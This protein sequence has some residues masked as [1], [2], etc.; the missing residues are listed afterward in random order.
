MAISPIHQSRGIQV[1]SGLRPLAPAKTAPKGVDGFERVK[2]VTVPVLRRGSTGSAVQA[3]QVKL[4]AKGLMSR[5]DFLNGTG[6]FGPRTETAVKRLQVENG[7]PVTGVLDVRTNAALNAERPAKKEVSE[8]KTDV[9]EK[10]ASLLSAAQ[11]VTDADDEDEF[12]MP[13]EVGM[14]AAA[15]R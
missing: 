9:F 5:S 14:A 1:G 15:G 6:V 2:S 11:T 4:V 10:P 12:T 7:L 3:M 8:V 13:V